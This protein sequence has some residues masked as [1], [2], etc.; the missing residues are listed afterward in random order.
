MTN[1]R[2]KYVFLIILTILFLATGIITSIALENNQVTELAVTPDPIKLGSTVYIKYA[3]GQDATVTMNVYDQ[4]GNK[5]RTLLN[6]VSKGAGPYTQTWDGKNSS[7]VLVPDGYYTFTVEAKNSAGTVIGYAEITKVAARVPTVSNVSASPNLFNPLLGEQTTIS[8]DLSYE[9]KVTA[10]ILLGYNTVR[11]LVADEEIP[12]GKNS[13][14]WDGKDN[15]GIIVGDASYT[16]QIDAVSKLVST[17]KSANKSATVWV[18]KEPPQ[19]TNFNASNNPLKLGSTKSTI[20]YN[21]S[22]NAKVTLKITDSAGNDI[23]VLL[24]GVAKN[25]GYNSTTWDGTNS[26]NVYVPEGTYNVIISAVDNFGKNS[27]EQ[28]LEL[29]AAYQ[30]SITNQ[31]L[32][33]NPFNPKEGPATISYTISND[34]KVTVVI[35]YGTMPVKTLVSDELQAAGPQT[36]GW[37]GTDNNGN[38]LGD[39][40]YYYQIT[41]VSPTVEWFRSTVKTAFTIE[42]GAPYFPDLVLSPNPMKIGVDSLSIKYNLSEDATVYNEIY[43][44]DTLIRKVVQGQSKKAGYNTDYWDGKDDAGNLVPEGTYTA[45]IRAVDAAGQWG[46]VSN[47]FSAGYLPQVT[48]MSVDPYP[49]NPAT[50]LNATVSFSLSSDAR[51]TATIFKGFLVI[52]TLKTDQ[53]MSKGSYLLTWDGKDD[54]GLQ[55]PDGKYTCKIEAA[56]PTISTFKSTAN[57]DITVEAAYPSIT[58]ISTSPLVVKIGYSASIR[59]TLS[60]PATVT[61]QVLD[62]LANVV[63]DFRPE[64]KANGGY[65]TLAWDTRDNNG[66]LIATGEYILRITAVD[67]FNKST[68]ERYAFKAGAVPVISDLSAS[69]AAINASKGEQTTISFNVSED[70]YVTVKILDSSNKI[71]KTLQSNKEQPAGPG[72]ATWDGRNSVGDAVSGTFTFTVDASSVIGYFKASQVKGTVEVTTSV[73]VPDKCMDCHKSYPNSHPVGNCVGCHGDDEPIQD[74]AFCHPTWPSHNDGIF[75]VSYECTYCHNPTYNYKIPGHGDIAVVHTSPISADCQKCHNSN[76]TL[77]HPKYK[78]PA[79]GAPYDCNTCHTSTVAEVVYA[80]ANKVVNCAACHLGS[81]HE[82]DHTPTGIQTDCTKCH[83]DSLTQ[84]HLNNPTTQTGN[85]WTCDTCHASTVA[86]IVYAIENSLKNC[87]VCHLQASHEQLHAITYLDAKCTTCHINSL[88]QEH[89]NNP[90]TQTDPVT[91]QPKPWTCNTCHNSARLEVTWAI[92]SGDMNCSACHPTAHG[93]NLAYQVPSDIPRYGGYMWSTPID[94]RIFNGESWV[95]AEFL[96]GG[97]ILISNRRTD[98]TGDAVWTLYQTE[99]AANGWTLV[100]DPPAAGTNF[101]NETFTKGTRKVLI[102]F[103][104]GEGHTASPVLAAGYRI[105]ILYK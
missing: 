42:K 16:I 29:V 104:G 12:A 45:K 62:S 8:F 43:R 55:V 70:S 32:S 63:R 44:G 40:S 69:P 51:V 96:L 13:I 1:L 3:L 66:Q 35:L 90:K 30:P 57:A 89:L 11:T 72:Y 58:G 50:S 83:K 86:G 74:C 87:E 94:A 85:A 98:V 65:F 91:G 68:T 21:L 9:A 105:E 2:Y 95:P 33:P 81:G 37:D 47:D 61:V 56:S 10:K 103:Y 22:E 7:G 79:T 19:I 76:L 34:A 41:A 28:A 48:G 88:T 93:I 100:S 17:F 5:V 38:L 36:I 15:N 18:E 92:Q 23:K 59:Y 46:Q 26:S 102:W 78:Y 6:N 49:F 24:N 77:E 64:L 39:A 20:S 73:S 75:L 52:R 101:F 31:N 80:I 14:V 60:E 71:A 25:A 67:N 4:G 54:D 27:G 53:L 82:A 97:K 99:M 84:E